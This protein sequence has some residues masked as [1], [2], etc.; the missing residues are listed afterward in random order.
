MVSTDW[1][2]HVMYFSA[3]NCPRLDCPTVFAYAGND[4]TRNALRTAFPDRSWYDVIE[5]AGVL[6]IEPVLP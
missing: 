4:A 3:L 2:V 1:W 5:R 6:R